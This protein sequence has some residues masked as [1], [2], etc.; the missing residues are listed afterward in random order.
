MLNFILGVVLAGQVSSDLQYTSPV[1]GRIGV[2]IDHA[3]GKIGSVYKVSPAQDAGILKNDKVILVDNLEKNCD[4]IS[5]EPGTVVN[6]KLLRKGKELE[7]NIVR[8]ERW[9]LK[10]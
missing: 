3:S 6:I 8:I 1:E 5:G 9:R 4:N 7:F 2:K 10:Y